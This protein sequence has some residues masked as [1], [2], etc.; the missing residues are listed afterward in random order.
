MG[1]CMKMTAKNGNAINQ[2]IFNLIL[3]S[4]INGKAKA[5]LVL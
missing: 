4:Y 3:V 5:L 2:A 1:I